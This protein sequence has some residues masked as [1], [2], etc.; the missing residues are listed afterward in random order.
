MPKAATEDPVSSY[1]VSAENL[2]ALSAKL[3][4]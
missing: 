1:D 3:V 4:V 2:K